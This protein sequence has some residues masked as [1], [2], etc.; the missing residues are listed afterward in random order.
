MAKPA[1]A[2]ASPVIERAE[3]RILFA[4]KI[5]RSRTKKAQ[6]RYVQNLA[7]DMISKQRIRVRQLVTLI[8][9][10]HDREAPEADV[11]AF[12]DAVGAFIDELYSDQIIASVRAGTA[13]VAEEIAESNKEVAE[14]RYLDDPTPPNA[15]QLLAADREYR[16]Q[17]RPLARCAERTLSGGAI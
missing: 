14:A 15:L 7:D 4:L 3:Q 17:S 5:A 8:A 16:V 10:C 12:H 11:R 1:L 6:G 2:P 13:H 9:D